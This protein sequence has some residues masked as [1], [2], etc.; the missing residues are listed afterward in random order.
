MPTTQ[1]CFFFHLGVLKHLED[2]KG[3][4]NSRVLQDK[5][6]LRF[7]LEVPKQQSAT[8][9]SMFAFVMLWKS[10]PRALFFLLLYFLSSSFVLSTLQQ[11][12]C[13]L[14]QKVVV[15]SATKPIFSTKLKRTLCLVS[16][17]SLS[18]VREE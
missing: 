16:S 5:N 11:S 10:S 7:L 17:C 18:V 2:I 9:C 13:P 12:Y 4:T 1:V 15:H 8:W 6:S 3:S 14:H